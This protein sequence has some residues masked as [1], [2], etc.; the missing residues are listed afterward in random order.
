MEELGKKTRRHGETEFHRVYL[1][2]ILHKLNVLSLHDSN[3]FDIDF[4]QYFAIIGALEIPLG[5]IYR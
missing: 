3:I 2:D 1:L 5:I 4:Y